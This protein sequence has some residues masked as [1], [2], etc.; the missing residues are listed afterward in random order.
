MANSTGGKTAFQ[1]CVKADFYT[2]FYFS[3]VSFCQLFLYTAF[4]LCDIF[5]KSLSYFLPD[6]DGRNKTCQN[7]K[8]MIIKESN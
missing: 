5:T 1:S 2:S 4:Q 7:K 3:S 6:A 8:A